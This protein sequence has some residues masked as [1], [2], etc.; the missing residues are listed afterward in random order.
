[1]VKG[2]ASLCRAELTAVGAQDVRGGR[3]ERRNTS[4][5]RKTGQLMHVCRP[6][7]RHRLL[8]TSRKQPQAHSHAT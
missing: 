1:M 7:L 5:P 2:K 3:E 4:M 6:A 8:H